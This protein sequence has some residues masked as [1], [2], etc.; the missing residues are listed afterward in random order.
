MAEGLL[1]AAEVAERLG[2][3]TGTILDWFEAG[4]LPGFKLGPNGPVRFRLS[5]VEAYLETCRRGPTVC[6]QPVAVA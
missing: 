6:K 1:T 5:E 4:K 3:A 2:L